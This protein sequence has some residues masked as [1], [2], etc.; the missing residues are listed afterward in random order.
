M[1]ADARRN[2]E[3]LIRTAREV[4][5]EKGAEAPLDEIAKRAGVG[6]GTL[7]RHFPNRDA[8]IEAVYVDEMTVLSRRAEELLAQYTPADA[9][10]HWVREQVNWVNKRRGLS[11]SLKA[12]MKPDSDNMRLCRQLIMGAVDKLLA[13]GRAAGTV[14]P[15]L[16]PY[17][18][19][20]LCHGLAVACEYGSD[21]DHERMLDVV[22]GGLRP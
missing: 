18:L 3:L 14:R 8:L 22:V 4:F 7:Y 2:C 21:A 1:R 16:Q 12:A 19:V 5:A 9:L 17:D 6:A 13:A 11:T 10:Q 20:R 15:D